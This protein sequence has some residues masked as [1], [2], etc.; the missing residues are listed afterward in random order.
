MASNGKIPIQGDLRR[1][2]TSKEH[3]RIVYVLFILCIEAVHTCILCIQAYQGRRRLSKSDPAMKHQGG[4]NYILPD[5][6]RD[7][8]NALLG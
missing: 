1:L 5:V 2:Y 4:E 7:Y 6:R 8:F 3:F